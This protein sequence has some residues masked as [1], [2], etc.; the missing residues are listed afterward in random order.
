MRPVLCAIDEV[1]FDWYFTTS[2]I[3]INDKMFPEFTLLIRPNRAGSLGSE[4]ECNNSD[5][6]DA[7][8]TSGLLTVDPN[9]FSFIKHAQLI[10]ALKI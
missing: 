6:G 2:T 5:I 4:T 3:L 9:F 10:F 7:D 8:E 1:G